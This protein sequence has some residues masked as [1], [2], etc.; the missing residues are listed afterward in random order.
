MNRIM[1]CYDCFWNYNCPLFQAYLE[2]VDDEDTL[3][4]IYSCERWKITTNVA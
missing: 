4:L 1:Y 3:E 2:D